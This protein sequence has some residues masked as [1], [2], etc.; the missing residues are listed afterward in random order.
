MKGTVK[1]LII[2]GFLSLMIFVVIGCSKPSEDKN[3]NV[4]P[5]ENEKVEKVTKVFN[6]SG[7]GGGTKI[8]YFWQNGEGLVPYL[9]SRALVISDSSFTDVKPDLAENFE[10]LEDGKVYKMKLKD[11][12]KWSDGADLTVDDVKFSFETA[13]KV[14]LINGI[15]PENLLKIEGALDYKEG[16]SDNISGITFDG[17]NIT[18]KLVDTVG[19]FPR[20]LAQLTLIPKHCLENENPIELHNSE[21]WTNPITNG[22]FKVKE[23]NT[24]NYFELEQNP[25]YE[26]VKP[27]FDLIKF[28]YISSSVVAMQDG[29]S[30]MYSTNK[31]DEISQLENVS[32]IVKHPVDLLFYRY[33]I[34]N[35]SGIDG[36][37]NSLISDVRV[38]EA[39]MY[40]INREEIV[41]SL[42]KGVAAINNTGVPSNITSDVLKNANQY[43][44][45]PEKAKELLK[46]ANYDF[47]KTLK[48]AYYYKDQTSSDIMQAISYQLNQI[49]IKNEVTQ[50]QSDATTA[51]FKLR[52]Y[53]I[54]LKG[55]SSFGYE[56]WY[57][58]YSSKNV[59]FA[60]IYN[61]DKSFDDLVQK[62]AS[63]VDVN[64]RHNVLMELQKLEQEKLFKL[65]L[66]TIKN[67]IFLNEDKV[68]LPEDFKFGNP[69]YRYDYEFE[70][71]DLK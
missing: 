58:E 7:A 39:L 51:L 4:K 49:G 26:G 27:N 53:D 19:M 66:Y 10:I 48:L 29:K 14:S 9:L 55:F 15:F 13:L 6:L 38:R 60:N 67:F 28:N 59:N 31:Q 20:V 2:Y 3:T 52:K 44:Y 1:K 54:A 56:S 42:L 17:N 35:L 65:P 21:F 12:L 68:K 25:Y 22:M 23:I 32:G 41:N 62:L 69:F 5:N 70:K 43:E 33:F 36:K 45:N 57:G 46:E 71:W 8:G 11:G 40:A 63:T 47:N 16:K 64:D 34:A 37:G 50:I 30:Y 61:N 18:I 24:G